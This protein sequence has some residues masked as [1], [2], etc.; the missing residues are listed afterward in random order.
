MAIAQTLL[1]RISNNALVFIIVL[2]AWA[3]ISLPVL[4]EDMGNSTSAAGTPRPKIQTEGS[5]PLGRGGYDPKV[6]V[7]AGKSVD[8][9]NI[10]LY[11][12]PLIFVLADSEGLIKYDIDEAGMVTL[13]M[14]WDPDPTLTRHA[15]GAH[16]AERRGAPSETW[17]INPLV[18]A[19]AWFES[20]RDPKVRSLSLPPRT[21]FTERGTILVHFDLNTRDA[22]D[23]FVADL[24]GGVGDLPRTQLVF[25][26]TFEGVAEELCTARVSY[27]DIQTIERFRDLDGE[28]R[29]GY[30]ERNQTARIAEDIGTLATRASRCSD[31]SLLQKMTDQAMEQLGTPSRLEPE[32]RL[33]KFTDLG[34]DLKSSIS[35]SF[36]K[37][38]NL[39][40]RSQDREAFSN[41]SDASKSMDISIGYGPFIASLSR[42]FSEATQEG[43]EKFQ[44]E[45]RKLGI[46]GEWQGTEFV[47]KTL[48][49]YSTEEIRS[50][51]QQGVS[52]EYA[53][54]KGES[55][56]FSIVLTQGTLLIE[57]QEPHQR[58]DALRSFEERLNERMELLDE[59]LGSELLESLVPS[60]TAAYFN[61]TECPVGWEVFTPASG[62]VI[63][64]AT[65]EEA[66]DYITERRLG[67]QGG[68]ESVELSPANLPAH[69]HEIRLPGR[70]LL[71]G[72]WT[73]AP[74][75]G[76]NAGQ[77]G[78][79]SA[80]TE[81]DGGRGIAFSVLPPFHV[82]LLCIKT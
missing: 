6:F 57:G 46:E 45:L 33:D 16:F 43:R 65:I 55:A 41:A 49:V 18:V 64:A 59:K 54:T 32:E 77:A 35:A 31:A 72:F 14:R 25:R 60:G 23:D 39:V 8:H 24:Q 4:A 53:F 68:Q 67:E 7:S 61:L 2:Q 79:V 29:E 13:Y 75:W 12:E 26:Y 69:R 20:S 52:L 30:V 9:S 47:A 22:A 27:E 70:P 48:D 56:T 19:E 42:E 34:D 10:Y 15:I 5:V 82:L 36:R 38:I 40:S 3:T 76:K 1:S 51:W 58:E 73:Q 21:S 66:P 81:T 78:V 62:R 11:H 44:D 37:A 17:V 63:I 74:A 80:R 50:Q 28:G 71:A